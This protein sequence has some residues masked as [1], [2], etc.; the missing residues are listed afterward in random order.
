MIKVEFS[1]QDLKTIEYWSQV[2]RRSQF[3]VPNRF[4]SRYDEVTT[5]QS[6]MPIRHTIN[7]KQNIIVL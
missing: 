5:I 4:L 7:L 3:A 2:I 1:E 6:I